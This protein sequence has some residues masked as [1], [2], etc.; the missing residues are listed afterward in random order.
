MALSTQSLYYMYNTICY[1]IGLKLTEY[2]DLIANINDPMSDDLK[3]MLAFI[4]IE[5]KI[6]DSIIGPQSMITKNQLDKPKGYRLVIGE[7][8]RITI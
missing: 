3:I 8:S 5:E 2:P 7:R 4:D 1:K 6:T